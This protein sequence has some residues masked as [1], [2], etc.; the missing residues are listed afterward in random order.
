MIDRILPVLVILT[1]AFVVSAQS[2]QTPEKGSAERKAI[3]DVIRVPVEREMKQ[4]IVFVVD[5]LNVQGTWAFV[6]GSMQTPSGGRPDVR[7]TQ[8]AEAAEAG[9]FDSNFF[10]LLRRVGGKW[11]LTTHAIGCTDV[12]YLDWRSKYRAPKAIF[13]Y[14]E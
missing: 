4:K 7:N 9:A 2:V 1:A 13:P 12:C 14:T 10:A 11:K 3:M 6:S 8:Y 5:D